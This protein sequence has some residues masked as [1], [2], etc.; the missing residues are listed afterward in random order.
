MNPSLSAK[1]KW[2]HWPLFDLEEGGVDERARV[3]PI[4]R[5]ADWRCEATRRARGRDAERQSLPP[6]MTTF[7][8]ARDRVDHASFAIREESCELS[9]RNKLGFHVPSHLRLTDEFR[10]APIDA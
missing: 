3:R 10:I 7:L 6:I 1:S 8:L 2:G 9:D 5:K 4:G